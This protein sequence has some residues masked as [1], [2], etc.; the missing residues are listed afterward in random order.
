MNLYIVRH[1]QTTTNVINVV[2]GRRECELTSLG[3]NE[4]LNLKDKLSGISFDVVFCSPLSR[5]RETARLISDK[6]V[7]V[8][9][10]LIERSYG[11]FE[12]RVKDEKWYFDCW[13]YYKNTNFGG[14]ESINDLFRRVK[15]IVDDLRFRYRGKNVLLVTHSGLMRA[16]YYYFN[17]IPDD[18]DLTRV[19]IP[20]C[21][22]HF[23]RVEDDV[24]KVLAINA[25]SSSLKFKMYEM[26]AEKVL[27]YGYIEKIGS[28]SY[29][30][31]I[32]DKTCD[33]HGKVADHTAA[34]KILIKALFE[35]NI[36]TCLNDIDFIGHRVVNGGLQYL[37][38]VIDDAALT[39]LK[40]LVSLDRV[41]MKG[42]IAGIK[43]FRKLIPDV[44]QIAFYDTAFHHTI[45]MENYLYAVP[46]EWYTDYGV[47]KYGFH[48]I[49]CEYITK[50]AE[51]EL[52][53][54]VN[55]IICHIGN[56]ASVTMV[57]NS[58]SIDNSM[59]FTANDGLIMGTRCGDIDYSI[60]PYLREK[61]GMT[62]NQIDKILWYE[63]GIDGFVKG[64]FDNRDLQ[65]EI[66]KGNKLAI[67][68]NKMYV[69][70]VCDYIVKYYAKMNRIDGIVFCGG[71]GENNVSFRESVLLNLRKF[72][73]KLDKK[74]NS[75]ITKFSKTNYGIIS[76]RT[77]SVPCYVIPTDEELMIA[78]GIVKFVGDK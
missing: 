19:Q 73:I 22:V 75:K 28:D 34:V 5:A 39:R 71:V 36:I 17:G 74:N 10:R 35:N 52:G 6:K 31:I 57:E 15:S 68:I 11:D 59:G 23:Y 61:T 53:R 69:D 63:S 29:W 43:A 54:K 20:N 12:G 14:I 37:P 66:D 7:V 58:E 50:F 51:K 77:S 55:L 46:Y 24:M 42:H 49:S 13:N 2:N 78:R 72:G 3:I 41:H 70:R 1:G 48:G 21:E 64:G 76:S 16:F 26:P 56:G 33:Y 47:R 32:T 25:G 18:G 65:K 38:E 8:D 4:A 40:G 62:L 30:K 60:I 27:I 44:K 67:I 9:E 45:P